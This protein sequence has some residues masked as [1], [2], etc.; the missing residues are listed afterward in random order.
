M[1]VSTIF[2][3]AFTALKGRKLRTILTILGVTIGIAAALT[4]AVKGLY[5]LATPGS[6]PYV[7]PT[8][9][10]ILTVPDDYELPD[11][12]VDANEDGDYLDSVDDADADGLTNAEELLLGTDPF[13]SDSDDDGYLDGE[14]VEAGTDPLDSKS[15]YKEQ[16]FLIRDGVLYYQNHTPFELTPENVGAFVSSVEQA[17]KFIEGKDIR[18]VIVVQQKLV[19]IVV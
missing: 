1:R 2:S 15:P 9:D 13:D 6:Q 17:A 7:D 14:E 10:N 11:G 8:D 4:G 19:N 3:Y 12:A 18:K 16:T 5:D